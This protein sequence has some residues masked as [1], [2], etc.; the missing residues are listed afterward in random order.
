MKNTSM[1]CLV[2]ESQQFERRL[3]AL[4]SRTASAAF[5]SLREYVEALLREADARQNVR[6]QET[7]KAVE[8]A[9]TATRES[10][11]KHN[12]ILNMMRDQG[13]DF[14]R[15]EEVT[16]LNKRIDELSTRVYWMLGASAAVGTAVGAAVSQSF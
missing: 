7:A 8:V 13:A 14:V 10:F 15:K 4:E 5:V 16:A 2:T 1:G 12:G 11:E 6:H 9:E 3:E